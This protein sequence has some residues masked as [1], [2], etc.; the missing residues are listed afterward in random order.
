MG[1]CLLH[2]TVVHL[3]LHTTSSHSGW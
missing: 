2:I 3:E 1:G